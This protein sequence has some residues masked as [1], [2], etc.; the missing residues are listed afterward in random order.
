MVSGQ[1]TFCTSTAT[2]VFLFSCERWN[3]SF[4]LRQSRMQRFIDKVSDA[5]HVEENLAGDSADI[6]LARVAYAAAAENQGI[7]SEQ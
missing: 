5:L 4:E 1:E 3:L 2:Q 6:K 7:I